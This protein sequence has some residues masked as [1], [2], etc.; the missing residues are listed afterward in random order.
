MI[1]L[2]IKVYKKEV[3]NFEKNIFKM[4]KMKINKKIFRKK[5]IKVLLKM[6]NYL[7]SIFKF[8]SNLQNYKN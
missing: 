6:R 7:K 2:M 1:S 3:L 8:V 5:I 4:M